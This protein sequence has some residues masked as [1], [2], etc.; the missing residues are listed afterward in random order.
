[1]TRQSISAFVVALMIAAAVVPQSALA[2]SGGKNAKNEE[3][4]VVVAEVEGEKLYRR[5]LEAAFLRLPDQVKQRGFEAIFPDLLDRVIE[6]KLLVIKGRQEKLADD[7]RVKRA[8]KRSEDQFVAQLYLQTLVEN[9][10][11]PDLLKQQYEAFLKS[12]PPREEIKARHI[13]LE[14][15]TDAN[16]MLGHLK[17]GM[18]FAEAAK[19]YST[20]PSAPKGGD[21]G[22]FQRGDMVKPFSDAAFALQVGTITPVPVKTRFGYHVIKVEDRRTVEPP[23]FEQMR[24]QLLQQAGQNVASGIMRQLAQTAN[25]KKFGLDGNP[26]PAQP[27]ATKQ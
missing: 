24:P 12:N 13:L 4:R 25:V 6:Q 1:M 10:I 7:E 20:G 2:Q 11:S 21:L 9:N 14:S 26:L 17:G 27:A 3:L 22:Y 19:K 16:N 5:D 8:V 15:E 18:D 23:S